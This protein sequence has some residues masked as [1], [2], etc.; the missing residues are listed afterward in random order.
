M[1]KLLLCASLIALFGANAEA[2]VFRNN[3][4]HTKI[5]FKI[6]AYPSMKSLKLIAVEPGKE[7]DEPISDI[8]VPEGQT[9]LFRAGFTECLPEPQKG[10]SL[11]DFENKTIMAHMDSSDNKM[12]CSISDI[13]NKK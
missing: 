12:K 5:E 1:K 6:T 11:A 10:Q 13:V 2:T 3:I 4:E 7:K 9:V 8:V